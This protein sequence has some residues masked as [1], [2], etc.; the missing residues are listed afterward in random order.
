VDVAAAFVSD[1]QPSEAIDPSETSFDHPP[2]APEFLG[3]ILASSGDARPNVAAFAGIAAAS[4]VIWQ[5]PDDWSTS[6]VVNRVI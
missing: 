1:G 6:Y 2:V 3:G 4:V 5:A